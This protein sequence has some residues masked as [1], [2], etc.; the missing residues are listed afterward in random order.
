M[1]KVE[2][3]KIIRTPKYNIPIGEAVKNPDGHYSLKIKKAKGPEIEEVTL[4][5][6][7]SMVMKQSEKA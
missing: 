2:H 3:S 5:Q 1:M 7:F 6:L 4:D